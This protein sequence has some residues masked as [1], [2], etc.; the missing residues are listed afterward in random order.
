[1]AT[2]AVLAAHYGHASALQRILQYFNLNPWKPL[3][4]SVCLECNPP[5][6]HEL[7]LQPQFDEFAGQCPNYHYVYGGI[8]LWKIAISR[9]NL[10]VLAVLVECNRKWNPDDPLSESRALED[11]HL[12]S[13]PRVFDYNI[14]E[15]AC[16]LGS[17][18]VCMYLQSL[19]P[20]PKSS[21]SVSVPASK[22][23]VLCTAYRLFAALLM[24]LFADSH[25]MASRSDHWRPS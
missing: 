17:L 15:F 2:A 19:V 11:L 6:C 18:P 14:M 24:R 23:L 20:G 13:Q 9:G 3:P 12:L 21:P 16:E 8:Y 7:E 25:A 22:F 1:M 4:C 10:D 5:R